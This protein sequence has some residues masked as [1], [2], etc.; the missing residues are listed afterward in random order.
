[1]GS[2]CVFLVAARIEI[3]FVAGVPVRPFLVG[4]ILISQ[5]PAFF[6]RMVQVAVRFWVFL[7]VLTLQVPRAVRVVR[8]WKRRVALLVAV[9]VYVTSGAA[10][11]LAVIGWLVVRVP[12]AQ[13]MRFG[14]AG[15]VRG[16]KVAVTL[17]ACVIETVQVLVPVQSPLQPLNVE[18]APA[19]AVRVTVVRLAIVAVQ[20]VPQL[21]SPGVEVTVPFP[22]LVTV[23]T[24]EGVAVTAC[25]MLLL[26][27]ERHQVMVVVPS[28]PVATR[29]LS[30]FWPVAETSVGVLKVVAFAVRV[31]ACT[32]LLLLQVT[33][34]VPSGPVATCGLPAS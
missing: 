28:G 16:V 24:D 27:L 31:A 12:R 13:R 4:V 18:P 20:V 19:V 9:I 29:G 14:V 1:M 2:V 11:K 21:M 25:T 10:V 30:A 22:I 32:L 34:V 23:K 6:K 5:V 26:L 7:L 8:V 15:G 33:V 17:R 3:V